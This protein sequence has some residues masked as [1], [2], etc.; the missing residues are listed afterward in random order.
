VI[1]I[2]EKLPIEEYFEKEDAFKELL[3]NASN[4]RQENQI[5]EKLKKVKD[6]INS[7]PIN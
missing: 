1:K 5:R 2:S 3:F 7:L 4:E 6:I